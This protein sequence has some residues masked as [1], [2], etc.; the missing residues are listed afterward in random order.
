MAID[1][2]KSNEQNATHEPLTP[3]QILSAARE[4]LG[5]SEEDVAKELY[6]TVT[7]VKSLESDDYRYIASDTFTRGY[8]RAYAQLLKIDPQSL[9]SSYDQL[10]GKKQPSSSKPVNVPA[11]QNSPLLKFSMA[12]AGVLIL[13]WLIS[14]WF[15]DNRNQRDFNPP[16]PEEEKVLLQAASSQ[17]HM[18]AA[19]S[20]ATT[21]ASSEQPV[22]V[23]AHE[24]SESI[25]VS[26]QSSF[27]DASSMGASSSVE[28]V[29]RNSAL[30]VVALQFSEECWVEVSDSRGDVLVAELQQA[31]SKVELQ[32]VAPFDVK[33]GN[34]RSV[35]I[36][37]NGEA[38][39]F[40]PR[41]GSNVLTL[42]VER[43]GADAPLH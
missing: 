10:I 25:A 23:I 17:S 28:S 16:V 41:L 8:L 12:I 14:V 37:L 18:A 38:F 35:K 42:K 27:F 5:L 2:D 1:S 29:K 13:M 26:T 30:D 4:A 19:S 20:V 11:K 21:N 15:L 32:G 6:M 3:G 24:V 34:S 9:L 22:A 43:Q 7:R 31:N 36:V 33:L 39:E 40:N